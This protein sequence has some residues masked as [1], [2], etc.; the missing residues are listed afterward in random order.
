MLDPES[1]QPI[2]VWLT[3]DNDGV[4]VRV[5]SQD[6]RL[7]DEYRADAPSLDAAQR[8]IAAHYTE[9]GYTASGEWCPQRWSTGPTGYGEIVHQ[10]SCTFR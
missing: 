7:A 1:R 5:Y 4:G 2:K 10:S 6:N 9:R 3:L 8:E